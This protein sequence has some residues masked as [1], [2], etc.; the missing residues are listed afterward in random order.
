VANELTIPQRLEWLLQQRGVSQNALARAA[1]VSPQTIAN[2]LHHGRVPQA[3]TTRRWAQALGV[4]TNFFA[5][6]PLTEDQLLGVIDKAGAF[7][8][9]GAAGAKGTS[10]TTTR[11][12]PTVTT[13]TTKKATTK[14]T[15]AKKTVA[16]PAVKKTTTTTASKTATKP[17]AKRAT[18]VK[19]ATAAKATSPATAKKPVAKKPVAKKAVVKKPATQVRYGTVKKTTTKASASSNGSLG[20]DRDAL[21]KKLVKLS[22]SKQDA[23]ALDATKTLLAYVK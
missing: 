18:T 23:V 15:A 19:K 16:K 1:K 10:S 3:R 6:K 13:A 8:F 4:P 5:T 12:A 9:A 2:T 11:K 20:L 22:N 21:L 14:S 7:S 17:A